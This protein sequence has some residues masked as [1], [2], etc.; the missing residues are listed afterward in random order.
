MSIIAYIISAACLLS[1]ADAFIS[2]QSAQSTISIQ[3]QRSGYATS[4][5]RDNSCLHASPTSGSG[6]GSSKKKK[7]RSYGDASSKSPATAAGTE[8]FELQELRAQ[9][10]TI[11]KEDLQYQTLSTEKREELTK[12][13]KAV[14]EK[15][16]T[17]IDFSGRSDTMGTAKFVAGVEGKSWRMVFSTD[18][19]GEGQD[20]DGGAELPYG[21]TVVL[22][23]GEFMGCDGNL[24]YVLKFSKQIMGLRE[25]VAKST[26][27]VDVSS[28]R[29]PSVIGPVNPGVFSFQYQDIKTNVF[30]M[31]NLPVGFF[32]LLKGRTT[33]V[34]TVWFDGERWIER[35]YLENGNVVYNV[36]VRDESD[37][38]KD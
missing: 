2:L 5:A 12:Y 14:V 30:G 19:S 4:L 24:D 11:L 37:E 32:G 6:F 34:D 9:L 3:Q 20:G 27:S 38:G 18:P 36:Y 13:V 1:T 15:S 17:P 29:C 25:L 21:S 16:Q 10:Q 33:Y 7:T 23:I 22:R 26:C 31:S 35:N 8:L 28:R